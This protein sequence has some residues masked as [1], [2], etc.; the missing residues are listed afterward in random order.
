LAGEGL[1]SG[2]PRRDLIVLALPGVQKFIAE[3][4]STSDVRAA[5]ITV[6]VSR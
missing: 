4:R 1:V 6:A 2:D 5:N 3:A